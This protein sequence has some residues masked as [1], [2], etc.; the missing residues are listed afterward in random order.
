MHIGPPCAILSGCAKFAAP[1][2]DMYPFLVT[3]LTVAHAVLIKIYESLNV[4]REA[5]HES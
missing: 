5:L 1:E 4:S 2:D 3:C